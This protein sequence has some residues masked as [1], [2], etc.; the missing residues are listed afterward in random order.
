MDL[1]NC[2]IRPNGPVAHALGSSRPGSATR[3]PG[4]NRSALFAALGI[5]GF[6]RAPANSGLTDGI[7][8]IRSR[9]RNTCSAC[10]D[11]FSAPTGSLRGLTAEGTASIKARSVRAGRGLLAR[12]LR[13]TCPDRTRS[14]TGGFG[15]IAQFRRSIMAWPALGQ[16]RRSR[17]RTSFRHPQGA[18]VES[19]NIVPAFAACDRYE[20]VASRRLYQLSA[21][22]ETPR[23]KSKVALRISA[24]CDGGE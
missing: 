9:Q 1:Q 2:A 18:A 10:P 21:L 6:V 11:E 23:D 22:N 19:A 12:A 24:G 16:S 3:I 7:A 13:C 5:G 15:W 14:A 8:R 17:V 20:L 4:S